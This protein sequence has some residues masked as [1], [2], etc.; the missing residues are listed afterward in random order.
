MTAELFEPEDKKKLNLLIPDKQLKLPIEPYHQI[1]PQK[2]FEDNNEPGN[3]DTNF[4]KE[5][6]D[7]HNSFVP[8]ESLSTLN[9]L[10]GHISKFEKSLEQLKLYFDGRLEKKNLY[11]S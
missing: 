5:S 1:N 2:S 6:L 4:T 8:E 11:T 3:P 9:K 10:G 7:F